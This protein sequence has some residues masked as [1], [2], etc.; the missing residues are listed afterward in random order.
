MMGKQAFVDLLIVLVLPAFIVGA[1]YVWFRGATNTTDLLSAT[2]WQDKGQVAA[3]QP[4]AKTEL[5]LK[6]LRSIHLDDSLF[7]DPAYLSLKTYTIN[8]PSVPISR[9]FPFTPP[10]IVAERLRDAHYNT[11]STPATTD[12][13]GTKINALGI[14]N[15]IN[16][17]KGK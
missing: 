6:T 12:T 15:K 2:A 7:K 16:L 8:I 10:P 9:P 5:A 3:N 1:Y 14:S 11:K 17:L 4:G 13:S